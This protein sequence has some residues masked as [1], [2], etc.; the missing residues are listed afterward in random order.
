[1]A[2]I[3]LWPTGQTRPGAVPRTWGMTSAPWGTSAWRRLLTGISRPL[4]PNT[5]AIRSTMASSRT[6]GTFMTSAMASLVMSSWVGPRPPQT[7]T[8][9][10]RARAVRRASTMR[11][12]L[13]PT[14]V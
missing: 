9:S 6:S 10:L 7:I 3:T 2:Y 4:A 8:A 12:R 5:A 14:L 13:S 1:M 11:A